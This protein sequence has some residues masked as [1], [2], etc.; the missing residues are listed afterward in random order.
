MLATFVPSQFY[1]AQ[2]DTFKVITDQMSTDLLSQ[3]R[4]WNQEMFVRARLALIN[5]N[6]LNTFVSTS[7]TFVS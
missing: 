7:T 2:D 1:R 4:Y 3:K 6:K 5:L